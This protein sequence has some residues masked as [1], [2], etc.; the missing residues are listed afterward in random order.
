MREGRNTA[1]YVT[2][3]GHVTLK[4]FLRWWIVQLASCLPVVLRGGAGSR[5]TRTLVTLTSPPGVVPA[6]V[7]VTRLRGGRTLPRRH[8]VALTD[9]GLDELRGALGSGGKPEVTLRLPPGTLLQRDVALPIAA[10]RAPR[11]VLQFELDR[12][13]PFRPEDVLWDFAITARDRSRGR[14]HVAL[15]FIPLA[16]LRPLL[17]AL[18]RAGAVPVLLEAEPPT[19]APSRE[20]RRID[21]RVG[22]SPSRRRR[23]QLAWAFC[24]AL[25]AAVVVTP[26]VRQSVQLHT[27]EAR[28]DA[29]H[30]AVAEA[31]TLRHRAAAAAAGDDVIEAERLRV[32]DPLRALAAATD[33]LPDDTWL[34]DLTLHQ[35]KVT[36]AGQSQD[37]VRLISRLSAETSLRDPSFTSP[38][39]RSQSGHGDL[40]SIGVELEP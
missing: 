3:R 17:E 26:F 31:N 38:V 32:G 25:A 37:A 22:A 1:R 23:R 9:A 4:D 6:T 24:A 20:R 40:F 35:R 2:G 8:T 13:T 18:G 36:M 33:A 30:P 19:G 14:L 21:P 11:H 15:T 12:L 7:D 10:E 39:T 27:V 28:I 29:L 34:T 5:V 16:P